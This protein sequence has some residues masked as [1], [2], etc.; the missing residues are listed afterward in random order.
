MKLYFEATGCEAVNW[1]YLPQDKHHWWT[2]GNTA[3]N[4]I[5]PRSGVLLDKLIVTQAVKRFPF[6]ETQ[7]LI[8]VF[9]R[10]SHWPLS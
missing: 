5:T 6:Y 10:A 2:L 7:R 1:I 3:L 8:T 9:T 4:L